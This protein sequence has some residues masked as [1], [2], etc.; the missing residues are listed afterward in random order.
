MINMNKLTGRNF[1]KPMLRRERSSDYNLFD[2][3]F[4]VDVLNWCMKRSSLE[5][6]SEILSNL[7]IS[8]DKHVS[9]MK[10][11]K[12]E[13]GYIHYLNNIKQEFYDLSHK[14]L[15]LSGVIHE[16]KNISSVVLEKWDSKLNYEK[17]NDIDK[18]PKIAESKITEESDDNVCKRKCIEDIMS[19]SIKEM[20]ATYICQK[21]LYKLNDNLKDQGY[22]INEYEDILFA[23]VIEMKCGSE[24]LIF[25]LTQKG[26]ELFN[27][28]KNA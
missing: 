6:A 13:K 19:N 26:V 28:C 25:E 18:L 9:E 16:K 2:P 8:M 5:D 24:C 3:N 17:L 12:D 10:I 11:E 23:N 22:D 14:I 15:Y 1:E 7:Y 20:K 27:K 21:F 4:K